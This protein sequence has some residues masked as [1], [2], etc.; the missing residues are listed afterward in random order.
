MI[1]ENG[2]PKYKISGSYKKPEPLKGKNVEKQK[3]YY[4]LKC[5]S[6][7]EKE[8]DICRTTGEELSLCVTCAFDNIKLAEQLKD[9]E[10]DRQ[11]AWRKRESEMAESIIDGSHKEVAELK[12]DCSRFIDTINKLREEAR[13]E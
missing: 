4:K 3:K 2:K 1:S 12:A 7:S 11:I 9:E 13:K 5:G 6:K 10:I 8:P